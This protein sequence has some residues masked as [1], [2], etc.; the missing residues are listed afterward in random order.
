M[1][2]SMYDNNADKKSTTTRTP[3]LPVIA[4]KILVRTAVRNVGNS[5]Q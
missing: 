4:Y 5:T 2:N 1:C 3:E